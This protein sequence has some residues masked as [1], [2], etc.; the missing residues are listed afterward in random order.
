[1]RGNFSKSIQKTN[2]HLLK[3]NPIGPKLFNFQLVL[4]LL[5]LFYIPL[6]INFPPDVNNFVGEVFESG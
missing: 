3:Y 1:M 4:Q 2:L 5:F 6:S